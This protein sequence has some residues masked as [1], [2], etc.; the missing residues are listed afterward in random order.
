LQRPV[1]VLFLYV[2]PYIGNPHRR[3]VDPGSPRI[4]WKVGEASLQWCFLGRRIVDQR[5]RPVEYGVVFVLLLFFFGYKSFCLGFVMFGLAIRFEL[6]SLSVFHLNSLTY[7]AIRRVVD[8]VFL[9]F[10]FQSAVR[11]E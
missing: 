6:P 7:L 3:L 9:G 1:V 8:M 4:G 11:K 5:G 10:G 2:P